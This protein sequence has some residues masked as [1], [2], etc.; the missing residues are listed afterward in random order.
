MLD[1]LVTVR[2]SSFGCTT[3]KLVSQPSVAPLFLSFFF[4]RLL[5]SPPAVV[6]DSSFTVCPFDGGE[7]PTSAGGGDVVVGGNG[8][9]IG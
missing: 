7:G 4:F 9:S 3:D 8:D 6:E 2:S 1:S 5:L